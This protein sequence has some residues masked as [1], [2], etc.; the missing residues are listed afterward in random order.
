MSEAD[1]RT[2]L[3]DNEP[4]REELGAALRLESARLVSRPD[5]RWRLLAPI[6]ETLIADFPPEADDRV[7]LV[8]IFLRRAS[9][10]DYAGTDKWNE[11]REE[12][13]AEA[14]N[15]DAMIG[16][17]AKEPGLPADLS[18]AVLG[19]CELH[20]F[21]GLASC[22]SVPMVANR[23]HD[24]G[25]ARGEAQCIKSLGD[26]ALGRSD[27]DA[28]RQRYEAALPLYQKIGDVL[29]EANCILQLGNIALDRSDHEAARERYKAALPLYRKVGDVLGEAN[30]IKGLGDIAL[31]RSDHDAA[32]Q[33]YEAALPLFQKVG[34][35]LGEANCSQSLGDIA[36]RQGEVA[37]A[38]ERW[39]S[40]LALYTK[41]PEPYSTGFTHNRLRRRA[42]TPAEAAEHREAARKAWASIGRP[43]L[44][45]KHLGKD[46]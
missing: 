37:V 40:A 16:V 28:A 38:R 12:L 11:V 31:A 30:C 5:G 13:T 29:G 23:F 15:L 43:D 25:D 1:S 21:T 41:I 3:S 9:L 14:G 10:G 22:A 4:T 18:A 6:R 42:A 20:R 26:I 45:E 32:R 2:I 19:L 39:L 17:A 35:V 7:R 8:N 44:I 33:R 34:S 24:A 27:Y 46:G 36:E